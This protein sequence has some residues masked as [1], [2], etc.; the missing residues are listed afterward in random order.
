MD[1]SP[2][3]RNVLSGNGFGGVRVRSGTGNV[4]EGNYS[5]TDETGIVGLGGGG[6]AS[7][8]SPTRTP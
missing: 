3:E 4:V 6:T 1:R 2:Y 5:G 7:W 8:S